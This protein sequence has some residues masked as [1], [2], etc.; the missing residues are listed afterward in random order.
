MQTNAVDALQ[1]SLLVL[2]SSC[3]ASA[4]RSYKPAIF[5]P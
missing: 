1:V 5:A 4:R 2:P 3:R